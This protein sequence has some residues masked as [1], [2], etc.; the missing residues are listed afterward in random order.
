MPRPLEVGAVRGISV[1]VLMM[2]IAPNRGAAADPAREL[3]ARIDTRVDAVLK[4]NK[5]ESAAQVT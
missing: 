1:F 5:V 4:A 3:S 2:A